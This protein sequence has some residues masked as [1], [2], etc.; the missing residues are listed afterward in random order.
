MKYNFWSCQKVCDTFHYLLDNM[1][2]IFGSKLY[3]QSIGFP[4][5]TNC[6]TLVADLFLFCYEIDC[7]LSISDNN[8]ALNPT[9]RYLDDLLN[10]DSPHF[11]FRSIPQRTSV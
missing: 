4:M 5:V 2:I 8:Q 9:S 3:R 1:Y 10:I 7:M 6:D 11:F